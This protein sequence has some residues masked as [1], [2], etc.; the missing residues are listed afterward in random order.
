MSGQAALAASLLETLELRA[1]SLIVTVWG[2]AITA[3]GGTVWLGSLIALMAPLGL[4]ERV[5]RTSVFRLQK[6]SWLTSQQVGR[7]SYYSLSAAGLRRV[8][9]ASRRI[10]ADRPPAWD[11]RWRIVV[12]SAAPLK[13][14]ARER[15]KREFTLQGFGTLAPGV[16]AH[17]G[18]DEGALRNLLSEA[19]VAADSVVFTDAATDDD[20]AALRALVRQSWDVDALDEAY[21]QFLARFRPVYR[22]LEKTARLDP[23]TA[24]VI[25]G[26]LVHD[27]RRVLLRD[28]GLPDELLPH[29]WS[30]AAVR[31]LCRNLYRLTWP[32]SEHYLM[33]VLETADGPLPPADE[34]VYD[35]FGGLLD[36]ARE[37]KAV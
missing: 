31:L 8:A 7:R 24:F 32:A 15:L 6:D 3:H 17:P 34:S 30:G 25:R 19:G 13:P 11:G 22:T 26:L 1:K 12:T 20:P 29:N 10:Y 36:E 4:G 27:Y 28:P 21:Q 23:E 16:H 2:D 9:E 5:V 35:R 14:A 37:Q 18:P 33:R